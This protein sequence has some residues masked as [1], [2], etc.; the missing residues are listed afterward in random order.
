[1]AGVSGMFSVFRLPNDY[2]VRHCC[3]ATL[4]FVVQFGLYTYSVGMLLKLPKSCA[5][6]VKLYKKLMG[7]EAS[8]QR[9][10]NRIHSEAV[11]R[12]GQS[13]TDEPLMGT[14]SYF[15]GVLECSERSLQLVVRKF[16]QEFSANV[17]RPMKTNKP[18]LNRNSVEESA[19]R[20]GDQRTAA[21]GE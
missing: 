17:S 20:N 18:V 6:P 3:V 21:M 1:M 11:V 13:A 14:S 5:A 10:Y 16:N 15:V 4:V 12:A 2:E 9:R 7:E 19:L 8:P